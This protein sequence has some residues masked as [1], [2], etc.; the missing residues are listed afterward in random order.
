MV[1]SGSITRRINVDVCGELFDTYEVV[2]NEHIVNLNTG[3]RSDTDAQDP[4][5]YRVAT[6][7]GGLFIQSHRHTT[8]TVTG[9]DGTVGSYVLNYD[10]TF[11]RIKPAGAP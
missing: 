7:Y 9:T 6:N 2:S 1:V 10:E 11:D 8:T 4:N 5:V 3:F